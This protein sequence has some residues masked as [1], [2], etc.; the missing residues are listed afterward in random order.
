MVRLGVAALIVLSLA[1]PVPADADDDNESADATPVIAFVLSEKPLHRATRATTLLSFEKALKQDLRLRVLDKDLELAQ[2]G[3]A[4]PTDVV[5]EARGLLATGEALLQKGDAN[6]ALPRLSTAERQLE[7]VMAFVKKRELARAQFLL[8]V[9][10]ATL[11]KEDE[12]RAAFVRLLT[13]RPNFQIDPKLAGGKSIEVFDQ[14]KRTVAKLPTSTVRI[15][16]TPA[17]SLAYVDGEFVGFTPTSKKD[18]TVGKHYVTVRANGYTREVHP[19]TLEPD[20]SSHVRAKLDRSPAQDALA[21]VLNRVQKRLGDGSLADELADLK[22]ML[23]IEHVVFLEVSGTSYSAYVYDMESGRRLA[24]ASVTI[25]DEDDPQA[26]FVALAEAVY[27]EAFRIVE[28]QKPKPPKRKRDGGD[29]FYKTWW[30]WT[31]V[32]VVAVAA[33]VP[34]LMSDDGGSASCPSGHVCGGVLFG[35]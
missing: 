4:I 23:R 27:S 5:S 16:A 31:G 20:R 15:R 14:A 19:V 22:M 6:A 12:A 32:G 34:L 33:T 35:F 29:P 24:N 1:T 18:L 10:Y 7:S 21:D 17:A 25:G 3:G 2:Q 13:W 11:G 30:F 9:A 26:Q 28:V 8:G